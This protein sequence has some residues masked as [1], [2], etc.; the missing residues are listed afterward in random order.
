[1]VFNNP[2]GLVDV[3]GQNRSL[4]RD[5]KGHAFLRVD[6]YD[7]K[8]NVDGQVDL[9]ISFLGFEV[10]PSDGEGKVVNTKCT[11]QAEDESLADLWERYENDV[12]KWQQRLAYPLNNCWVVSLRYHL[13]LNL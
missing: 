6:L 2:I 13:N 5:W 11:S 9:H 12:P 8:G 10:T 4:M 1:M 7:E 3:Y